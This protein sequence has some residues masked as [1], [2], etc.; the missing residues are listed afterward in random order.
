MAIRVPVKP[1]LLRGARERAGLEPEELAHRFPK[2]REWETE[3]AQPTFKQLEQYA[4][5]TH[6]PFGY[7]FLTEPPVESLPIPDFRTAAGRRIERP[8]PNLLDTV[9]LC[10]Q[11]QEWYREY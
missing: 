4:R 1:E 3:R 2:L 8:S 9:F 11:R 10:Q 5:V 6:A 7:F